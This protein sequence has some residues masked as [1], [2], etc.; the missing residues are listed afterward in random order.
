MKMSVSLST[1]GHVTNLEGII[2]VAPNVVSDRLGLLGQL[3][4]SQASVYFLLLPDG[5]PVC[6]DPRAIN[7]LKCSKD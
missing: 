3:E 7:T 4:N 1:I 6:V 2:Q 5:E